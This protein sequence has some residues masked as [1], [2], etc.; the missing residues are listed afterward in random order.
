MRLVK[1]WFYAIFFMAVVTA[2]WWLT[3]PIILTISS[4]F[5]FT[6]HE[7]QLVVQMVSFASTIWG[8]LL[9]VVIVSWALLNSQKRDVESE[10]F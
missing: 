5:E 9:D 10:L 1:V 7:A 2:A 8:P 4:A 6:I 3:M